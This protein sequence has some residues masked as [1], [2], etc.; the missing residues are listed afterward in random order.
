[1]I[2]RL[3]LLLPVV[4]VSGRGRAQFQPIWAEDAAAGITAVVDSEPPP[5]AA[6]FDLSGPQTL[7]HSEVVATALRARGHPGGCGTC[8]R[9]SSAARCAWPRR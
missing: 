4:P 5:K 6:R 3:A 2:D 7:S 1:M 8:P 9:R